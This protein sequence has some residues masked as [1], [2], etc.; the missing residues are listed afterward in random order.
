MKYSDIIQSSPLPKLLVRPEQVIEMVESP[1]LFKDME[2]AG[3]IKPVVDHHR[4][5]LYRVE[6]IR[7][8]IDRLELNGYPKKKAA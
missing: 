1:Q 8:A 4:Q 2:S 7:A 3:W 6:H 5:K